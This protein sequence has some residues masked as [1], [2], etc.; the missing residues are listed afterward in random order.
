[1]LCSDVTPH[2]LWVQE[3]VD[4][5]LVTSQAAA[6]AVHR[7]QPRARIQIIPQP[8]RP[9]FYDPPSAERARQDLGLPA[10]DHTVLLMSGAWG[11]GPLADTAAA[12][13]DAGVQVLAVAG[14]NA[15]LESR[16]RAAA[17][18]RPRMHVF[19]YTEQIP[20]LMSAADLVITSSGDTCAEARTV[21]RPML[22]LDVVQGH[23]RDNLQHELEY[24]D[25]EVVS[26]R[27][28]EV[29]RSALAA[30]D[31]PVPPSGAAP[32]SAAVWEAA[33]DTAL[34]GLGLNGR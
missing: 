21:G 15:R 19:G 9:G 30:L 17:E 14:R 2:R 33:F 34:D 18:H 6:A 29:V 11:L 20:A 32:R 16:L 24:G 12:L 10:G 7:Y 26:S 31:R 1:V 27:P 5:Y 25:A 8:V 13:A 3:H 23:G 4:L 28:S 22:L